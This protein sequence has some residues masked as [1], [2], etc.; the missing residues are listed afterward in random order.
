MSGTV[1]EVA[2]EMRAVYALKS[3]RIRRRLPLRRA[4]GRPR[5]FATR[6]ELWSEVAIIAKRL[7]ARGQPALVAVRSVGEA[8]RASAAL[9]ALAVNHRVLS[10]AQNEAEAE[11]VAHAGELGA[12]TVVTNMAG[13]GTDIKL[14]PGVAELGGLAVLI[15]ER[16]DSRRVDRQL[17]GRCARQGDPG[18]VIEFVTRGDDVLTCLGPKWFTA[19]GLFPRLT[20]LAMSRAQRLGDARGLRARIQLLRRDE[21]MTKTMAFAGGLD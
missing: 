8:E 3:V 19:L 5:T 15:C 2:R 16:H 11:I 18:L 7:Q 14:G 10:A 20:R 13:R 17:I 12:I 9:A 1:R 4:T 6:A 21:Q